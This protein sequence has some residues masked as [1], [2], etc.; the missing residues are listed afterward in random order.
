M[1]NSKS[2]LQG[3]RIVT[4]ES[5]RAEDMAALV[6]RHGGEPLGAPSMREI[7]LDQQSKAFEFA[8]RL[9]EGNVDILILL[10]GVGTMA[11][12]DAVSTQAP[13]DDFIRALGKVTI[14][15]RGPKPMAALKKLGLVPSHKVPEPNTW[16]DLLA[17]LRRECPVKGKRVA[18]QEYGN[19]NPDL[20]EGL[21]ELGAKVFQIPIYRWALPENLEP[22]HKAID[23]I[24]KGQI[25]VALFT[26]AQQAHN[27]FEVAKA[28]GVENALNKSLRKIHVGSIGSI[29]SEGLARFGIR[30]FM[31]PSSPHMGVLVRELAEALKKDEA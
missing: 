9:F 23:A 21:R 6:R 13:R 7:P 24:I 4:F 16:R 10:T 1:H 28:Q 18:V 5:R 14:V 20:L 27:L 26:S 12:V 19:T 30:P 2:S 3:L 17:M 22:L 15:V 31:E 29:T 11:L 25:D 8:D